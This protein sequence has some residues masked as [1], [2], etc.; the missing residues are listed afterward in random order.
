[1][2]SR[3]LRYV[4]S[5]IKCAWITTL[6]VGTCYASSSSTYSL[7]LENSILSL[8]NIIQYVSLGMGLGLVLGGLFMLKKY[9]QMR[10][11]MSQQMT[12][13]KP[14]AML[15]AGSALT[16]LPTFIATMERAFWGSSWYATTMSINTSED[17]TGLI[18]PVLMLVRLLGVVA[19]MRAILMMTKAGGHQGQPGAAGKAAM[20]LIAGILCVNI[21]G[22]VD[23]LSNIFDFSNIF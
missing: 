6:F 11:M 20:H 2:Q 23:I 5:F 19:L 3:L 22:T 1:M 13:T 4:V 12:L 21:N 15:L 14:L 8:G 10:T 7:Y 16:I 9:G 17:W 18:G